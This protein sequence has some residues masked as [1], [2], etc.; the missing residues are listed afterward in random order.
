MHVW[1]FPLMPQATFPLSTFE[2]SSI[3]DNRP[4]Y[5]AAM[6]RPKIV[7]DAHK[8]QI[9]QWAR[10]GLRKDEIQRLLLAQ[11]I[12]IGH[13][14]LATQLRVWGVRYNGTPIKK[15]D[16]LRARVK[17]LFHNCPKMRD[18]EMVRLLQQEGFQ[19]SGMRALARL[20]KEC[21]LYKRVEKDQEEKIKAEV[22]EALRKEFGDEVELPEDMATRGLADYLR[23]EG[24]N[25]VGR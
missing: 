20:R 21:G 1:G 18:E 13:S 10:D 9:E 3:T 8:A 23:A 24:Y 14:T 25:L 4:L 5:T 11:N 6:A 17:D 22:V 2:L 16:A 12:K 19:I 7:L 15:T